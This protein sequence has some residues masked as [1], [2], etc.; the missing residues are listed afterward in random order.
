MEIQARKSY[1]KRGSDRH[2]RHPA[3]APL[4]RRLPCSCP[5]YVAAGPIL[6]RTTR[7]NPAMPEERH[8]PLLDHAPLTVGLGQGVSTIP[9]RETLLP[10]L[11]AEGAGRRGRHRREGCEDDTVCWTTHTPELFYGPDDVSGDYYRDHL[12]LQRAERPR[13]ANRDGNQRA[14]THRW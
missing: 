3:I 5:S 13:R 14:A 7:C 1:A 6:Y 12:L 10:R 9:A 8:R 4:L 2:H 11:V